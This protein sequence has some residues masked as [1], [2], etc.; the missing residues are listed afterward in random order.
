MTCA[1]TPGAKAREETNVFP[2]TKLC[3]MELLPASFETTAKLLGK[4]EEF[5]LLM[6]LPVMRADPALD[7]LIVGPVPPSVIRLPVIIAG[8]H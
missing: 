7:K 2:V 6:K 5:D 1:A 3:G 4:A 8:P